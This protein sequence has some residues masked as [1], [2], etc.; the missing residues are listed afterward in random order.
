[1]ELPASLIGE[2]LVKRGSILY[3]D[4][5]K[6]IDHPKFFVVIGVDNNSVAGFFY[7]NSDINR[8]INTKEE[9]LLMQYPL[10]PNDYPFLSHN[11]YICATSITKIPIEI[12]ALSI[13]EQHTILKGFLKEEHLAELLSKVKSSKLFSNI[14]KKKYF[15]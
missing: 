2:S 4:I 15:F 9:Q 8:K 14:D 13:K 12:L 6:N 3:S 1:M 5:F 11:S 7:V 10:T